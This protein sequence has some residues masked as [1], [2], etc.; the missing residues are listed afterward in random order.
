MF[1]IVVASGKRGL[2]RRRPCV[3]VV[4]FCLLSGFFLAVDKSR[5]IPLYIEGAVLFGEKESGDKRE[6]CREIDVWCVDLMNRRKY[7]QCVDCS[8][9]FLNHE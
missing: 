7:I 9:V 2:D 4:L 3:V 1:D 6:P 8:K 5:C